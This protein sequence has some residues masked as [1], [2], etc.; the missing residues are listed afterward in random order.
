MY[1]SPII[2][3]FV[4]SFCSK[5]V[6]DKYSKYNLDPIDEYFALG[7]GRQVPEEG[8]DVPSLVR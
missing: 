7:R 3:V 6:P 8:I 5:V 2:S 4:H 1:V